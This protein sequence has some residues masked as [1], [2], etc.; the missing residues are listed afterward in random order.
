[1]CDLIFF[2]VHIYNK[3]MILHLYNKRVSL[4]RELQNKTLYIMFAEISQDR[5]LDD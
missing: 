5:Y 2:L 1:M 3:K 4:L